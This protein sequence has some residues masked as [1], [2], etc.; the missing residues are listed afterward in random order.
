MSNWKSKVS[1]AVI[2]RLPRYY[3]FLRDIRGMGM[4]RVSSSM[5]SELSGY[6]ASQV[7]Q[8]FNTFGGFGQQGYGYNVDDLMDG[9]GRILGIDKKYSVVIIG[10]G[11]LGRALARHSWPPSGSIEI[12]SLFDNSPLIVDQKIG[13]IPVRNV[14]ELS[15]FLADP[16][17]DIGVITTDWDIAQSI[18]NKLVAGGIKGIWNFTPVDIETPGNVIVSSVHLSDSLHELIYYINNIGE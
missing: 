9:I 16:G 12:V 14:N 7:R 2:R 5:L 3:R 17:A 8:D 4:N 6:T 10:A 15:D 11:N 1:P 18:A 13:D